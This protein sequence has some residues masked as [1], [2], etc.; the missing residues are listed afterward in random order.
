[1]DDAPV[2]DGRR[3]RAANTRSALLRAAE[4][5]VAS[6]GADALTLE[7]VA[8][9]AGVSKGGLLYH[10]AT[11][12]AMIGAL[13][14]DTLDGADRRLDE[15][16]ADGS[17]G[18]FARAY[19]EYVRTGEHARRGVAAGVFASAALDSGELALAQERFAAWQRRLTRD[20]GL[21]PTLAL[22]ARIVGDGLWLIDLFG[23]APP[24]DDQRAAVLDL[25]RSLLDGEG[26]HRP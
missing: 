12:E 8:A 1:M 26:A 19:L 16:A 11:K 13:L 23:L 18:S 15:L 6:D 17:D 7:R 10:F 25:V 3:R 4:S 22:L 21:D 9:E 5:V 2:T 24:D 20:D 14:A